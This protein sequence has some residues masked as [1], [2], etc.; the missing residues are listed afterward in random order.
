MK[1]FLKWMLSMV[2]LSYAYFTGIR[3]AISKRYEWVCIW[4]FLLQCGVQNLRSTFLQP[5]NGPLLS[6]LWKWHSYVIVCVSGEP[7]PYPTNSY[8]MRVG[9]QSLSDLSVPSFFLFIVW[10]GIKNALMFIH[11]SI[12][13]LPLTEHKILK[14]GNFFII[15]YTTIPYL[16]ANFLQF[17]L[18]V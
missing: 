6:L 14:D 2:N 8:S 17:S 4:I 1:Q 13:C 9:S 3:K 18:L 7:A 15:I 10:C 16:T 5:R 11:L 12:H